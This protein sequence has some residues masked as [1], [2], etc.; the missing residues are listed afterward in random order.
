MFSGEKL[1]TSRVKY[2][3]AVWD[4]RDVYQ[5]RLGRLRYQDWKQATGMTEKNRMIAA[6]TPARELLVNGWTTGWNIGSVRFETVGDNP[7]GVTVI[8]GI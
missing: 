8:H 5:V 7:A 1:L 6:G 4:K 3:R 2:Q